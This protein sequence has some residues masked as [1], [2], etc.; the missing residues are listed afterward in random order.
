[1][2]PAAADAFARAAESHG[3]A[4]KDVMGR[5]RRKVAA[6]ARWDAWATLRARSW[7]LSQIGAVTGHDHTTVLYGLRQRAAIMDRRGAGAG[8][9]ARCGTVAE[10]KALRERWEQAGC[11]TLDRKALLAIRLRHV[12][13]AA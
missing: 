12:G 4:I 2:I 5:S 1:M 6:R 7:S 9:A 11:L 13:R 8:E 10:V 3:L